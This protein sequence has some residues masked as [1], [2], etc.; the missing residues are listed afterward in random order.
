[1]DAM[2]SAPLGMASM[3]RLDAY[4][5]VGQTDAGFDVYYAHRRYFGVDLTE[6]TH[7][8]VKIDTFICECQFFI[9]SLRTL[10]LKY[11]RYERNHF[12]RR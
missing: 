1:M 8:C 5:A 3:V 7:E 6:N 9:V 4:G 10:M 11:H 12:S 2:Y